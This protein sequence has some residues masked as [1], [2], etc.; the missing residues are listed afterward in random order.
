MAKWT[1]TSFSASDV[2]H[3]V[4]RTPK[5]SHEGTFSLG[6][7]ASRAK[8]GSLLLDDWGIFKMELIGG[9]L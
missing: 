5:R 3:T 2:A 1:P 4:H 9:G 6:Q 7:R 8:K